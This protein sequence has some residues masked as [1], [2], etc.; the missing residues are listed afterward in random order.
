MK[1]IIYSMLAVMVITISI[2]GF[3]TAISYP[4]GAPAGKTGSPGDGGATC[5]A[6]GCHSGTPTTVAN[7]ITSNVPVTGYVPGTTYTITVTV[8]GT[9]KKGFQVSPQNTAGTLLGTLTAGTGNK[10]VGTKYVTHTSAKNTA[11]AVWTFQWKAPSAG[12]GAV[13]FYGAFAVTQNSTKKST[14]VLQED[15]P[16][17]VAPTLVS[18]LP[19]SATSGQTVI[20]KGQ[21]FT[22]ATGVTF[23]GVSATSYT[24]TNDSTISAVVPS[25]ATS[26]SVVVTNLVGSSSVA[27]FTFVSTPS[28][29]SFLPT[30]AIAGQTVILKGNNFNNVI[31]VSFGGVSALSYSITNDSTISA[32]VSSNAKSGSVMVVNLAGSSTVG[33]F[34]FIAAPSLSAFAP[35]SA[36]KNDTLTLSGANFNTASSVIIGGVPAISFNV[37]NDS[38]IKAIVDSCTN[39]SVEI[40]TIAGSTQLAGFT[41]IPRT[42][43]INFE[44][45]S[46]VKV[47]PNP[48]SDVLF[49]KNL[50]LDKIQKVEVYNVRGQLVLTSKNTIAVE[51]NSLTAGKYF[52]VMTTAT[53]AYKET[54]I[55]K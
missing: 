28:L 26:G 1:K 54:V 13:T 6:S 15:V 30:S 9:G 25:N 18:F 16:L 38:T 44:K 27:G 53:K 36:Y 2:S 34:T 40:T 10:I 21:K 24:V 41:F 12:T 22:N 8:T 29:V 17:A 43:G 55:K 50:G 23:G 7:I 32:V 31:A 51:L 39:G 48:T 5:Q 14:L 47:Y 19:T 33:G 3:N 4:D 45:N 20:L 46:L 11:S 42:V 49:I 37:L 52:V 35:T